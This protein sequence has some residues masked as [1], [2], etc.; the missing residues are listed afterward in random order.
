MNS[1]VNSMDEGE[2][3]KEDNDVKGVQ[4]PSR[5]IP[6]SPFVDD[7]TKSSSEHAKPSTKEASSPSVPRRVRY[8]RSR[9]ANMVGQLQAFLPTL[10][11]SLLVIGAW[12]HCNFVGLAFLLIA[13]LLCCLRR[14][15]LTLRFIF[16][17]QLS[18]L[19]IIIVQYVSTF[20]RLHFEGAD[21]EL[22]ADMWDL[23]GANVDDV[24]N[25]ILAFDESIIL[26][27][28]MWYVESLIL[29]TLYHQHSRK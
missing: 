19:L 10:V 22:R 27:M 15:S 7:T 17:L 6:Q 4:R 25:G 28:V 12:L 23:Y 5:A 3:K 1:R 18:V 8:K 2:E 21:E 29:D 24:D 13:L 20:I 11:I 26:A 14:S 9:L 16:L